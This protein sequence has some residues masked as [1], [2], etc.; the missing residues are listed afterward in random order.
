MKNGK[1]TLKSGPRAGTMQD[2]RIRS[3]PS[4]LVRRLKAILYKRNS[5][6][7]EWFLLVA[8]ETANK[9]DKK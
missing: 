4:V 3:V 7:S 8:A 1:R 9:G 6:L 5:T 2:V